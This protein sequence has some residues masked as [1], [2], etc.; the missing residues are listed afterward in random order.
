MPPRTH[1]FSNWPFEF[2]W[3]SGEH[4]MEKMD[5]RTNGNLKR[6]ERNGDLTRKRNEH[7]NRKE[8]NGNQKESVVCREGKAHMNRKRGR[9]TQ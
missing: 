1:A 8:K 2:T 7:L 3:M 9:E 6:K 4:S 5:C